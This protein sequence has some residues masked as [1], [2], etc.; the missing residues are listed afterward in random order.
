ML[1]VILCSY[2]ALAV[3]FVFVTGKCFGKK[4]S[5]PKILVLLAVSPSVGS[6]AS[7]LFSLGL[8]Q[9]VM[10]FDEKVMLAFGLQSMGMQLAVQGFFLWIYVKIIK[11]KNTS[12]AVFV[13]M[14]STL[15]VPGLCG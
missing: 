9:E 6:L 14:C 12:I 7:F 13:Y 5:I 8:N 1:E 2:V 15:I 4:L 11:A 3:S 10:D